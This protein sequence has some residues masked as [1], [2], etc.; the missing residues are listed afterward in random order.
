[1]QQAKWG[2]QKGKLLK[3]LLN[4]GILLLVNDQAPFPMGEGLLE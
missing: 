4:G 2:V 1:M 3:R